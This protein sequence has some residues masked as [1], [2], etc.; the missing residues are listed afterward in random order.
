MS[1]IIIL[2]T[3]LVYREKGYNNYCLW[4]CINKVIIAKYNMTMATIFQLSGIIPSPQ[5]TIQNFL[6]WLF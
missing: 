3:L 4:L 6:L 2:F 5:Q 1:I